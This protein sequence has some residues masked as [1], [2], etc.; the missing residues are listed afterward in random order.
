M[1]IRNCVH[2]GMVG[3]E[4]K[5]FDSDEWVS[6]ATGDI[7]SFMDVVKGGINYAID[8]YLGS[9]RPVKLQLEDY[10]VDPLPVMSY[11][12]LTGGKR[13]DFKYK[14]DL[15]TGE[16]TGPGFATGQGARNEVLKR[17]RRELI[18]K[19]GIESVNPC[20]FVKYNFFDG[21]IDIG[22]M[23]SAPIKLGVDTR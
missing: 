23:V 14:G 15:E 9:N 2:I 13:F 1:H 20:L 19:Y 16:V 5:N 4:A 10:A 7:G 22:G 11:Y 3:I 12:V 6:D 8:V 17:T 21:M 18:T